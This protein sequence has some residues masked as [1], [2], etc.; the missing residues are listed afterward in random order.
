MKTSDLMKFMFTTG[1]AYAETT[2]ATNDVSYG[3]FGD[4]IMMTA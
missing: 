4:S 1:I 3:D 2:L